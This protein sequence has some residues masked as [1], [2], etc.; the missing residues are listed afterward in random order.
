MKVFLD[1]T[2]EFFNKVLR[3]DLINFLRK[4]LEKILENVNETWLS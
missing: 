4:A 3:H 2:A 1:E